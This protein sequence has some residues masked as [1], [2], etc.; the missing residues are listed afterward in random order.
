MVTAPQ[1]NGDRP[2][3][4]WSDHAATQ[5]MPTI[6][7]LV[8]YVFQTVLNLSE[9]FAVRFALRDAHRRAPSGRRTA[10]T[11]KRSASRSSKA[12]QNQLGTIGARP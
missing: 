1:L 7:L 8:Y 11:R 12:S 6:E 5:W 2:A 3:T 10:A 9:G 4:Q